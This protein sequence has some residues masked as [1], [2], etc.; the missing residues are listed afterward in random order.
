MELAGLAGIQA[1]DLGVIVH[2]ELGQDLSPVRGN[3]VQ[4]EQVLLN[5]VKN[6]IESMDREDCG[7]LL[8]VQTRQTDRDEVEISVTD[9][10]CGLPE[11]KGQA[12]FASFFTTKAD[13]LGL[14]LPISRSIVEAHGGRLWHAANA[15]RGTSFTFTLP[16]W[17]DDDAND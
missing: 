10:G 9:E 3:R 8:V 1:R 16:V 11:D 17:R 12:V 4:V 2:Y 14:G 15:G 7:K 6:G 5:L 13:G